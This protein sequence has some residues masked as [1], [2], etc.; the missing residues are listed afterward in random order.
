[1]ELWMYW[2]G[3]GIIFLVSFN[4]YR[5]KTNRITRLN[6][7]KETR[8][9]EEEITEE[10]KQKIDAYI[11]T[12]EEL[13][14]EAFV[15]KMIK[16][17]HFV[18]K[19]LYRHPWGSYHK[20]YSYCGFDSYVERAFLYHEEESHFSI[21]NHRF[22]LLRIADSDVVG[23][24]LKESIARLDITVEDYKL[25]QEQKQKEEFLRNLDSVIDKGCGI[26]EK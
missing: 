15:E 14:L 24:V 3:I 2:V 22:I 6:N 13:K 23:L 16:E 7:L 4:S 18:T 20:S 9:K 1:M 11:Q 21:E 12:N 8:K 17:V 26:G 19:T 10:L 25:T 5:N